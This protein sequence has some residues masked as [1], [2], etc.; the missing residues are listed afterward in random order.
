MFAFIKKLQQK[1]ESK[2]RAYAF[3]TACIFTLIV[4]VLWVIYFFVELG[5]IGTME[6]QEAEVSP[7]QSVVEVVRSSF[8]GIRERF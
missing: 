7:L 5:D 1:P 4:F 3:W 8:E 2:R 6:V